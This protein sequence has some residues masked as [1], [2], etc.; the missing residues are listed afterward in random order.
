MALEMLL[1][2]NDRV[3][4]EK[5]GGRG[6]KKEMHN[7]MYGHEMTG[8][9]LIQRLSAGHDLPDDELRRLLDGGAQD[10]FCDA[11]R[12]GLNELDRALFREADRVRRAVYGDRV[13]LRGLIEFSNH[14]RNDC[15]Y[16]GIRRSN[17]KLARYRLDRETI[18]GCCR[19]GYEL[20]Y[21]TFVLQGGEDPYYTD[22]V[23]CDIVSSVHDAFPDCAIT[24]SAGER[25]GESYRRLLEAGAR[26]YLLRHEAAS[27]GLY[28]RLHPAEMK[29]ENRKRC[30]YDLK[31]I[32]YQVGA[33]L[34]VGAPGQTAEH[35]VEDLRFLQELQPE[36]I[37]IGP[38]LHHRD[39]PLGACPDGSMA[40]TLRLLAI[41]RLM[42]PGALIPS[43]TALGSIDPRGRALGLQA[44]A[45][46]VM[47]NLS[48]GE[49]RAKYAIYENKVSSGTESAQSKAL[50]EQ[51][52]LAAGYRV[53]TDIGD[54]SG[55][56]AAKDDGADTDSAKRSAAGRNG[57]GRTTD[58]TE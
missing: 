30:L 20:G 57:T 58:G 15:L 16:C 9:K 27:E 41:L 56:A 54:P 55:W 3:K 12:D 1:Y 33:G 45:N 50:L 37:G 4:R 32:G 19:E 14:C 5:D 53:V 25:S 31:E 22:A 52:V 6:R 11:D 51:Q 43:T 40:L 17:E 29:L 38:F 48:P 44:G 7:K 42:F 13:F 26:R 23:L 10:G 35:L 18:L 21:R 49:V 36:M 2:Y 28:Q 8:E 47:P 46:V 24:L 39:T 34:M